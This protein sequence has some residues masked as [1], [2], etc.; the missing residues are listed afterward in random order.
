M[1]SNRNSFRLPRWLEFLLGAVVL[2]E[3]I[4]PFTTRTFGVDGGLHLNWIGEFTR[5]ISSGTLIP[6]WVPEA[7]DGFGSS[8]FYFYPP[9]TFYLAAALRF[10]TGITEATV[11]FQLIGLGA[12]IASFITAWILLRSIGSGR[13]QA[14]I[15]SALYGVAPLR[16]AELYSR[17]ALPT[18]VSYAFIPL[19]WMGLIRMVQHRSPQS[20]NIALVGISFAMLALTNVPMT[21]VTMLCIGFAAL[22]T[23]R[24]IDRVA[25]TEF[26]LAVPVAVALSAFHFFAVLAARPFVHLEDLIVYNPHFILPSILHGGDAPSAYQLFF[27]YGAVA[28]IGFAY[29]RLR[30][31]TELR[32]ESTTARI[33]IGLFLVIFALAIPSISL[34]LWRILPPLQLIQF[35]WRFY[36]YILL[37]GVVIIGIA[38]S[39]E[40]QWAARTVAGLWT[41][42]ALIP[43]VMVVLN[44][45]LFPHFAPPRVDPS[46]YRPRWTLARD[47][48]PASMEPHENDAEAEASFVSGEYVFLTSNHPTEE[49]F[50]INLFQSRQVTFHQFYWPFWHLYAKAHM[51]PSHPDS[52]GRAVASLPPG[53]YSAEWRLEKSPIEKAGL[54]ISSIAW[55]AVILAGAIGLL[56]HLAFRR[57]RAALQHP[58][59]NAIEFDSTRVNEPVGSGAMRDG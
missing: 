32:T 18:H 56:Q 41:A 47:D 10:A 43:A 5:L 49:R 16:I 33:G 27:L 17:S 54:W 53:H 20:G 59:G 46:E 7:F 26:A 1:T 50:S 51:V 40:M 34:P 12:T 52:I 21:M 22:I 37:F 39:R 42:G 44:L 25:I 4:A 23:W 14:L 24:H 58:R 30:K 36:S 8:C 6:R 9:L 45:H 28:V 11:L 48:F 13:Y 29:W 2:L 55:A 57:K 3:V 35:D 19:V 31:T 38:R 15:A